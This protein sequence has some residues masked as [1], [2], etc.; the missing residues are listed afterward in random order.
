[1]SLRA[2]FLK[3]TMAERITR[4][5]F[6]RIAGAAA[7]GMIFNS[8]RVLADSP[9]PS[10]PPFV[11][12]EQSESLVAPLLR[13]PGII[14]DLTDHAVILSITADKMGISE[15]Y[16]RKII[17]CESSGDPFKVNPENGASGWWQI[18]PN[19]ANF[20]KFIKHGWDFW[21]DRF[22]P[23]RNSMVAADI[24]DEQGA[25]AFDCS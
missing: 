14:I 3:H 1:M 5:K 2:F 10:P 20:E 23:Y 13:P 18:M 8:Q 4:K 25:K 19:K 16:A 12:P 24:W 7:G 11:N 15:I 21:A 17:F 6:L 22:N 9:I